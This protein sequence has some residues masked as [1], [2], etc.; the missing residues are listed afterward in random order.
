MASQDAIA[1]VMRELVWDCL[2]VPVHKNGNFNLVFDS[3]EAF[4]TIFDDARL[5]FCPQLSTAL[6]S[7]SPPTIDF[8]QELPTE[9][10]RRWGVYAIVMEK[11]NCLPL[12]YIGSGTHAKGGVSA[13][14]RQY[15]IFTI[16]SMP[17]YVRA[18]R[19]NGYSITSKGLLA[20]TPVLPLPSSVPRRRLL[21]VALEATFTF[22]FWSMYSVNK[23]YNMGQCC[24]WP[25]ESFSYGGLGSHSPLL[26]GI[27]GNLEL[28]P[29]QLEQ[30]ALDLKEKARKWNK[31][32]RQLHRE[33]LKQYNAF[34]HRFVLRLR[35]DYQE[36]QRAA[37]VRAKM[38]S[39][40]AIILNQNRYR[41]R[42]RA[43]KRFHC[44]LCGYTYSQPYSL[45]R[46]LGSRRHRDNVAK[47]EA[48]VVKDL[49]CEYYG[50]SCFYLCHM[51]RHEGG[52]RHK[53]RVAK[54]QA[55]AKAAL[56]ADAD[57][58]ADAIDVD[59]LQ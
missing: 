30:L 8:F 43:S 1:D 17:Y 5:Q 16:H 31:E 23:D 48:G 34:Y 56:D 59:S 2:S 47:E 9:S 36:R 35:P 11:K 39:R 24:P 18:A 33:E 58:N 29:E 12:L 45:R 46:H 40:P 26:E 38:L 42:V 4:T 19:R 10:H 25:R 27:V 51:K 57:G 52:E 21:V 49:R 28:S 14:L 50:Y 37:N 3:L 44:A 7:S 22:L 15:E 6:L 54:A 20:W 32:Y 55:E 13:R 41:A 53:A